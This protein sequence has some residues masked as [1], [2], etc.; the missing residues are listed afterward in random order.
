MPDVEGLLEVGVVVVGLLE[1][2]KAMY[3]P[4]AAAIITTTI[5]AMTT[6]L[7]A[8]LDEISTLSRTPI[9]GIYT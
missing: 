1:V 6:V 7:T 9:N 8:L 5:T 4:A 2:V 3:P